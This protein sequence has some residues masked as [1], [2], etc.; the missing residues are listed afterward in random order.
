MNRGDFYRVFKASLRDPKRSRVFV[1]VSRQALIES[2]YGI[3]VCAAVYSSRLGLSTQLDV[4]VA[5]GLKH[6]SSVHC[7]E[8]MSLPKAV[9]TH[10]VG[11]LNPSRFG[12]L[13]EALSAALDID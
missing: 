7:D 8:L 4:G 3:V 13:N 12:E 5:E 10:Y 2:S 11:S 9:L 6:D 1:V